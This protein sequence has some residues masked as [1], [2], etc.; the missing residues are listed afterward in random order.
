MNAARTARLAYG[1][2]LERARSTSFLVS[3]AV[4]VYLG[5]G[6]LPANGSN[7]R[8]FV[9]SDQYRPAY[10]AAWVGTLSALLTGLYFLMVGHYLVKGAVERD[11]RTGVGAV[12]AATRVGRIEYLASKTLSS[13]AILMS[14]AAVAVLAALV[15]QQLLAEDRR[16][17][18]FATLL[19]FVLLT[20]PSAL[21]ASASAVLFDCVPLL[22]GAL[23][24]IVWF[25]AFGMLMMM[26]GLDTPGANPWRDL[27]GAHTVSTQVF[28]GLKAFDPNAAAKPGDMN[29][30]VNVS[31]KFRGRMLTTFPWKG[32]SWTGA[33]VGSRL[34]WTAIAASLVGLAGVF[35]DRFENAPRSPL[36]RGVAFRWPFARPMRRPEGAPAVTAATL[37]PARRGAAFAGVLRAELLLALHGQNAWWWAGAL[38]LLGG[39]LFAPLAHVKVGWLP[40]ATFWPV[41]VWSAAGQRERRDG[42]AAVLFSCARPVSRLLLAT[43]CSGALVGL[44]LCAPA[45]VRFALAGEPGLLAAVAL[46]SAFASALALVLGVWSGGSRFF[47]VLWLFLWYIGPMH[48]VAAFDYTGVTAPRSP[49]LWVAYA[50]LTAAAFSLAWIGRT[51]QVRA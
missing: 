24:N 7:Y 30:G 23:G 25:F 32:L 49:Q 37:A 45:L 14:M 27:T 29:V 46:G 47:E 51:R 15:T 4:M 28:A 17:D 12:L 11:R 2:F 39:Q 35:F 43:W 18:V 40:V 19:P 22:R 20:V 8:T 44:A 10:G 9:M 41:F 26:G 1:D 13:F 5:A 48:A 3:M 31:P 38:V 33:T 16:V 34:M 42:V 50:A 21:F 6:M 36:T